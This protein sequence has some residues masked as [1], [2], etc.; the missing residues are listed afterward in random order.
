MKHQINHVTEKVRLLE[1][2]S[3][4]REK[5]DKELHLAAIISSN[6]GI[7]STKHERDIAHKEIK[8]HYENIKKISPEFYSVICPDKEE[9]SNL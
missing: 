2:N 6:I 4:Q 8:K 5:I 7:D 3:D 1:L 9:K